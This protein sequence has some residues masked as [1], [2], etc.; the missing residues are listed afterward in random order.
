LQSIL[1]GCEFGAV[2]DQAVAGG[3]SSGEIWQFQR[4][5]LDALQPL[6]SREPAPLLLRAGSDPAQLRLRSAHPCS[7]TA[8]EPRPIEASNLY[9]IYNLC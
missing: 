2:E 6:C 8:A 4:R 1:D 3:R 7:R 9:T 5:N